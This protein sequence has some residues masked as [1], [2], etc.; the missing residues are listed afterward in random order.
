MSGISQSSL[1]ALGCL[2]LRSRARPGALHTPVWKPKSQHYAQLAP[3]IHEDHEDQQVE[4][5]AD[6]SH[7]TSNPELYGRE[8][9]KRHLQELDRARNVKLAETKED[10][11][12]KYRCGMLSYRRLTET[13]A[14]PFTGP[15]KE[16]RSAL[17]D[18]SSPSGEEAGE[19][20]D[21]APR[22]T[23]A[24]SPGPIQDR[25]IVSI[26]KRTEVVETKSDDTHNVESNVVN[27]AQDLSRILRS[28]SAIA[29]PSAALKRALAHHREHTSSSSVHTYNTLLEYAARISNYHDMR[30]I[31]RDM[32]KANVQWDEGTREIVTKATMRGPGGGAM[33]GEKGS[34]NEPNGSSSQA[35][36]EGGIDSLPGL[37]RQVEACGFSLSDSDRQIALNAGYWKSGSLPGQSQTKSDPD[38]GSG[39][40]R[41]PSSRTSILQGALSPAEARSHLPPLDEQLSPTLFLAFLRYILACN[42]QPPSLA[43]SYMALIALGRQG[44]KIT[45]A[46]VRLLAHLYL[47]PSLYASF[48]PF[49]VIR[50]MQRL[51]K[52]RLPF[53]PTS[54][55]LEKA[56]L[57][58]RSRRNRHRRA[59]ELVEYFKR[60]WGDE[61]VDITCWRLVGRYALE[62]KNQEIQL[63]AIE[64]GNKALA[65]QIKESR[66]SGLSADVVGAT[67]LPS[68]TEDPFPQQG[69]DRRKWGRVRQA[70]VR[71]QSRARR[72]GAASEV[73]SPA[74]VE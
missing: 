35:G 71:Q 59:R 8:F 25:Q 3:Q 20:K 45:S 56:L 65:R 17:T 43:D 15:L 58:L 55:T 6:I 39:P 30:K 53:V 48:R 2:R 26:R 44:R 51:S 50:E 33:Q 18:A 73:S 7:G 36:P 68:S 11:G 12:E 1:R 14:F 69:L 66:N 74:N 52:D 23:T 24:I 22:R 28:T 13:F 67:T 40:G 16:T 54:E 29:N 63:F 46:N 27:L 4:D 38:I 49:W 62:A 70:I 9:V 19:P 61:I 5:P 60:K 10:R 42:P 21:S 57:S 31:L 37:M 34:G 72:A 41:A 64:G 47:H 32:Q